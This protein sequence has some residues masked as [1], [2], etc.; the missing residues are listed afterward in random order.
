MS[1]DIKKMSIEI[2]TI[3]FPIIFLF[4]LITH[5]NHISDIN[6]SI[7]LRLFLK[8]HTNIALEINL[9]KLFQKELNDYKLSW[10]ILSEFYNIIHKKIE[11]IFILKKWAI[12]YDN[13]KFWELSSIEMNDYLQNKKEQFLAI[14]DCSKGGIP[15]H[16]KIL[17]ILKDKNNINP[18]EIIADRLKLILKLFGKKL[19]N[20]MD[21]PLISFSEL[22]ILS[23]QDIVAYLLIIFEKYNDLLNQ[24]IKVFEQYTIVCC[25]LDNL[26]NPKNINI[27]TI[28]NN[29]E[30]DDIKLLTSK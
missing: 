17:S 12:V 18:Y 21:I 20:Y 9:K 15:F 7:I 14:Y 29:N 28:T 13:K 16:H 5:K 25:N 6:F 4:K 24:T 19:F 2:E 10:N 26:I 27:I 11:L 23:N 30:F 8:H 3:K 22:E 1:V